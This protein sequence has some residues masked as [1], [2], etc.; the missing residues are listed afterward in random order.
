MMNERIHE[1]GLQKPIPPATDKM[2]EMRLPD[3]T[4]CGIGFFFCCPRCIT[5]D[6]WR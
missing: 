3:S 1:T 6:S 4:F 5:P 2:S